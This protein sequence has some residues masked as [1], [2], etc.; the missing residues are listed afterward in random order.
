MTAMD[1]YAQLLELARRERE[2]VLHGRYDDLAQLHDERDALVAGL[3]G[4][5][6]AGAKPLLRET[7]ELSRA[8]ERLLEAELD[9]LRREIVAVGQHRQVVRSYG[10][11]TPRATVDAS[12]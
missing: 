12:A 5:A 11:V 6:P 1:A 10:G 3:A 4:P 7:L 8:N 9:R 2:L